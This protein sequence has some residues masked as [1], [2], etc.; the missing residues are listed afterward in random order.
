MIRT[1]K[2]IIKSFLYII[3]DLINQ[4]DTIKIHWYDGE[5]NFGDILNPILIESITGK[6][7]LNISSNC[8]NKEHLFVIGS[9]LEE[10]TNNSLVWGS[11]F[12]KETSI[13]KEKPKK[14]YAVR[15]P[16]T[17]E[18]LIKLGIDCPEIYGDPA[19]LMPLIYKPVNATKKYKI[20]I[21]PHIVDRDNIWLK[22][23]ENNSDINIINLQNSKPLEVIDQILTCEKIISS[24][25]HGIIISDA[26]KIPSLWIKFSDKIT[27]G[28]FKF[29]DYFLSVQ[30]N[31]T[32]AI[33]IDKKISM[34]YVLKQFK[35]YNINIDLNKLIES[36]P[37]EVNIK[38]LV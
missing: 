30:R 27:G 25:L 22:Q 32:K 12:I 33:T 31:D 10:V 38:V 21:I 18:K 37:Y 24:S 16:K 3:N 34:D 13:L 2:N 6:K 17:R 15:G 14:V 7:V 11:G 29:L 26:Y 23:F 5:K 28:N 35:P 4:K 8:Y 20:G 36:S 19:L 9:I 1:L